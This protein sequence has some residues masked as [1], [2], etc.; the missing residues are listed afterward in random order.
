MLITHQ[1]FVKMLATADITVL[2]RSW[3]IFGTDAGGVD[4]AIDQLIKTVCENSKNGGS[5]LG[6]VS[7]DVCRYEYQQVKDNLE[8]LYNELFTVKLFNNVRIVVLKQVTD[9]LSKELEVL[10]TSTRQTLSFLLISAGELK[11]TSKLRK[12]FETQECITCL[13]CYKQ[14]AKDLV[15]YVMGYFRERKVSYTTEVPE[16][17]VSLAHGDRRILKHELD[18][19]C[20]YKANLSNDRQIINALDVV[21]LLEDEASISIDKLCNAVSN[22]N[23]ED[24]IENMKQAQFYNI[25]HIFLLRALQR[26]FV[27]IMQIKHKLIINPNFSIAQVINSLKIPVFGKQ[28]QELIGTIGNISYDKAKI[29]LNTLLKLE[30]QVKQFNICDPIVLVAQNLL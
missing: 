14:D 12:I 27:N 28:L 3:L 9:S 23:K 7:I 22:R 2:A 16:M 24:L 25:N 26:Y 15:K 17:I 18:K 19:L 13:N 6:G 21:K 29:M 30:I 5:L 8:P 1:T 10:L 11:K 4:I 20:L